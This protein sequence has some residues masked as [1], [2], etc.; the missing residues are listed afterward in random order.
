M[1]NVYP[2]NNEKFS[3]MNSPMDID[4]PSGVLHISNEPINEENTPKEIA[5]I[6][7]SIDAL[8]QRIYQQV[9]DGNKQW[10]APALPRPCPKVTENLKAPEVGLSALVILKKLVLE[11]PL[12]DFLCESPKFCQKLT[13]AI[14]ALVSHCREELLLSGKAASRAKETING[15]QTSMILDAGT[16]SNTMSL[17]FLKTLPDVMVAPSDTVFV[18]ANGCKSFSMSTAVHLTLWLG[19][20]WMPIEAAVF[21]HK[22]YTLLIGRRP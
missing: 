5:D 15:V 9:L 10:A 3:Y 22:Q 20:V 2:S 18:M 21:N 4:T 17:P 16:Y 11:I 19:G 1:P 12:E 7:A 13:K 14:A 8:N 6:K